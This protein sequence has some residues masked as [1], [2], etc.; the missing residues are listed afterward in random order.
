MIAECLTRQSCEDPT[1]DYPGRA[2]WLV[3]NQMIQTAERIPDTERIPLDPR[4]APAEGSFL[5]L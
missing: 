3:A 4:D 5:P 2:N 1:W